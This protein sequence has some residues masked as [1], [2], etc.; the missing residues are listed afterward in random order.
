MLHQWTELTAHFQVARLE[1]KCYSA[2]V[3]Y[4]MYCNENNKAYLLLL[5]PVPEELQRVF[6]RVKS[7]EAHNAD[8]RKLLDDLV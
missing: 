1:E 6:K 2:E 8:Q 4:P 3:L 5:R 7:F